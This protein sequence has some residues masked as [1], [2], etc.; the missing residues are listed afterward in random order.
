MFCVC[1]FVF[2][3]CCICVF[4]LAGYLTLV[5]LSLHLNKQALNWIIIIIIIIT[6]INE[7]YW[8]V[9]M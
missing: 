6:A 7:E 9:K 8:D 5:L 2:S 4:V 1:V 3:L